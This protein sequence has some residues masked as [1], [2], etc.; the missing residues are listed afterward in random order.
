[1]GLEQLPDTQLVGRK[2]KRMVEYDTLGVAMEPTSCAAKCHDRQQW[3]V[4]PGVTDRKA[5]S[6]S[7]RE[8]EACDMKSKRFGNSVSKDWASGTASFARS[9]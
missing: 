5:L 4:S 2:N 8:S 7:R 1:M 6:T 9:V 3:D